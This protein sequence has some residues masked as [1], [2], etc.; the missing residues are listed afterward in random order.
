MLRLADT[1]RQEG[2]DEG[3]K[4]DEAADNADE[5]VVLPIASKL[6]ELVCESMLREWIFN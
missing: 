2:E 1:E 6:C 3:R 5:R 4:G